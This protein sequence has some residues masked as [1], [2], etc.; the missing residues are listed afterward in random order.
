MPQEVF[1]PEAEFVKAW[2]GGS[3]LNAAR[4]VAHHFRVS[5]LVA[6]RRAKDLNRIP[7][8]SF[9]DAV[10]A[11]YARFREIDRKKREKQ[12]EKEKSGGN[13]WASFDIRNGKALNTAVVAALSNSRTTFT[14]AAT[15]LGVN[16][17]STLRYMRRAGVQ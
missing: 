6:L 12:K 10:N 9:I 2:K 3:T 16:I 4:N 7:F 11:E 1:V 17:G 5:T 13:F 15:L 8:D 14:E